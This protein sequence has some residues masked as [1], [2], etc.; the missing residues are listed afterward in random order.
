MLKKSLLSLFRAAALTL[1]SAP[2]AVAIPAVPKTEHFFD[3]YIH[4]DDSLDI[5]DMREAF[6]LPILPSCSTYSQK[7]LKQINAYIVRIKDF[8]SDHYAWGD[9]AEPYYTKFSPMGSLLV[10]Y[11]YVKKATQHITQAEHEYPADPDEAADYLKVDAANTYMLMHN[12]AGTA[13][14]FLQLPARADTNIKDFMKEYIQDISDRLIVMAEKG[15]EHME[16]VGQRCMA[17]TPDIE[18]IREPEP[19]DF[20]A[21]GPSIKSSQFFAKRMP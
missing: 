3:D 1:F 13:L 4:H 21:R 5:D 10:E 7:E 15:Y 9:M 20:F 17:P 6:D 14:A 2:Q 11:D 16:R 18:Y 8:L 12:Y 19:E